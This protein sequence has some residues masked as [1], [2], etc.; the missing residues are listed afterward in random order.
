MTGAEDTSSAVALFIQILWPFNRSVKTP[1]LTYSSEIHLTST[2]FYSDDFSSIPHKST[3]FIPFRKFLNSIPYSPVITIIA[4]FEGKLTPIKKSSCKIH[5]ASNLSVPP[6]VQN[7]LQINFKY[8]VIVKMMQTSSDVLGY[9]LWFH[10]HIVLARVD[11]FCS[12]SV[13]GGSCHQ[14]VVSCDLFFQCCL[15]MS[16]YWVSFLCFSFQALLNE[17]LRSFL[18]TLPFGIIG[19]CHHVH[20]IPPIC[21][22]PRTQDCAFHLKSNYCLSL[23]LRW[24]SGKF[25]SWSL[26]LKLCVCVHVKFEFGYNYSYLKFTLEATIWKFVTK[27]RSIF[28]NFYG[29][30]YYD[31]ENIDSY[32]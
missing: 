2:Y 28:I 30:W 14:E 5:Q 22:H 29:I 13:P 10:A 11:T 3:Q 16:V 24:I 21:F 23:S 15:R 7:L 26:E 31:F 27:F 18:T 6:C 19:S 17:T 20:D 12:L 8:F 25:Q 1:R 4:W 32:S 9:P